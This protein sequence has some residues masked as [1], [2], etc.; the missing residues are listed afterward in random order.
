MYLILGNLIISLYKRKNM[1]VAYCVKQAWTSYLVSTLPHNNKK[2]IFSTD[3]VD[4][5]DSFLYLI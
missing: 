1:K 3:I 2:S 5:T 4:F